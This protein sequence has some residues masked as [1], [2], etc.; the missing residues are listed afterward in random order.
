MAGKNTAGVGQP[1]QVRIGYFTGL[2]INATAGSRTAITSGTGGTAGRLAVGDVLIR[3]KYG[4]DRG[5][6]SANSSRSGMDFT[7]PQT[8]FLDEQAVVVTQLLEGPGPQTLSGS[9]YYPQA[10]KGVELSEAESALVAASVSAG[11]VLGLANGST[12][13]RELTAAALNTDGLLSSTAGLTMFIHPLTSLA[14]GLGTSAIDILTNLTPGFPFKITSF[15]FVT[16]VAGTGSGA[17]QVF[18]LEIGTTNVTGGVLTLTL[19]SQA[20]IG[21]VTAAT[22]IT[23]AN[24]GS[25]TDT[26]SIEMAAGGTVFTA[27]AGYFVIGI[28]NLQTAAAEAMLKLAKGIALEATSGSAAVKK[29]KFA[30]P[31]QIGG[32]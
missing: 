20:T 2:T 16:T 15:A 11:A 9:T 25:A 18:N 3:D 28:Q 32:L 10:F 21:T 17:S 7:V 26:I 23:A 12:A 4:H 29:V 13:L 30:G 14:T 24:V 8:G 27:G 22:A 5:D 1:G 19:A 6:G 31:M